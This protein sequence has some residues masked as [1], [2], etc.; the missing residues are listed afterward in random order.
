MT[1]AARHRDRGLVL[2]AA[3]KMF[4]AT[5]LILAG[6]GALS[7]LS[8]HVAAEVRTW[9]LQLTVG[10]GL[11]GVDTVLSYL[12]LARPARIEEFGLGAI[13]Y[14]LIFA[15]EGVGLWLAKTW[16]EYLTVVTTSLLVPVEVYEVARRATALRAGTLLV[17]VALVVYLLFR[18]RQS[19][20]QA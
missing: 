1:E 8:P 19:E 2:I 17:N 5:L 11:R 6:L 13:V 10:R 18:L 7:L 9:L 20:R 15:T 12:N 3:F 14:G 4:K 16:A